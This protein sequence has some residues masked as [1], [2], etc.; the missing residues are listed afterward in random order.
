[1]LAANLTLFALMTG[2]PGIPVRTQEAKTVI[3]QN[4]GAGI[5][6]IGSDFTTVSL[7]NVVRPL[8]WTSSFDHVWNF[9]DSPGITADSG[10]FGS[11]LTNN[12]SVVN[13]ADSSIQ[14][15]EVAV[16]AGDGTDWFS[17]ADGGNTDRSGY[18]VA[19]S[20]GC[21]VYWDTDSTSVN[22][23]VMAKGIP[24]V[25]DGYGVYNRGV[26]S[27]KIQFRAIL[28]N[29]NSA[30]SASGTCDVGTGDCQTRPV[31]SVNE[32]AECLA[33][34]DCEINDVGHWLHT[35]GGWESSTDGATSD[36][37]AIVWASSRNVGSTPAIVSLIDNSDTFTIGY[38]TSTED[39]GGK[40][41]ECFWDDALLTNAEVCRIC[42]LGIAGQRGECDPGT[43]ANYKVCDNNTD[44]VD[45]LCVME[46]NTTDEDN[47][48]SSAGGTEGCCMGYNYWPRYG[49]NC[50]DCDLPACNSTR[51]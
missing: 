17:L 9:E 28:G 13:T 46:T 42:S 1:M 15:T 48:A 37:Q 4:Y 38:N 33:N 41:D 10:S 45:N 22:E 2:S 32:I 36:G 6:T 30:S 14:G 23:Y 39:I 25:N 50:H 12:G 3:A 43:Q 11:T 8:D 20:G 5:A 49:L 51:S 18:N 29:T 31:Y 35:V 40:V 26:T 21:W 34:G 24:D 19:L 27:S 16:L 47:C 7:V 44:C